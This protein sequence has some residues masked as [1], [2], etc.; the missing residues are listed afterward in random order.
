MYNSLLSYVRQGLIQHRYSIK[1]C[2]FSVNS[3]HSRT[4]YALQLLVNN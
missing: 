4:N 2:V 3:E 1:N